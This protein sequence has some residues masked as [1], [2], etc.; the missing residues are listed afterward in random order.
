MPSHQS[1]LSHHCHSEAGQT[2]GSRSRSLR[3][4]GP[5]AGQVRKEAVVSSMENR[6]AGSFHQ[7]LCLQEQ[8]A[9]EN[10]RQERSG[11]GTCASGSCNQRRA[12]NTGWLMDVLAGLQ[13]DV[14]DVH[15][16][17]CPAVPA[18]PAAALPA[19]LAPSEPP[20]RRRAGWG[21]AGPVAPNPRGQARTALLSDAKA[22]C[23]LSRVIQRA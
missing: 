17:S 11:A 12:V 5:C 19:P 22:G 6:R 3:R 15:P 10:K 4:T 18:L 21:A 8:K 14:L 20:A 16:P 23:Y 9:K 1:F 13:Q 7:V 2:R